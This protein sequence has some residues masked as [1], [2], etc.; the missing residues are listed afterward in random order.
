MNAVNSISGGIQGIVFH[1]NLKGS[2]KSVL[3]EVAQEL[4]VPAVTHKALQSI[5]TV[6][7]AF[8]RK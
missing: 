1:K 7:Q 3:R 6:M 2:F 4:S 8:I 5:D